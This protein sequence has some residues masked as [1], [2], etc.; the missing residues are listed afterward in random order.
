MAAT[1][2]LTCPLPYAAC[3]ARRPKR[4]EPTLRSR[5]VTIAIAL[6]VLYGMYN[7]ER[8]LLEHSPA[9]MNELTVATCMA[10]IVFGDRA[11]A[12]VCAGCRI[13]TDGEAYSE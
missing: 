12:N 5:L 7:G 4:A 3:A 6:A 9:S 10:G 8:W 1:R 11:P 13:G 2:L